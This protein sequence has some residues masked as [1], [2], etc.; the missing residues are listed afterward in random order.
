MENITRHGGRLVLLLIFLCMMAFGVNAQG[1]QAPVRWRTLVKMTSPTEGVIT[2]KCFLAEG[3]HVYGMKLPEG[4][5]KATTIDF[6]G[7]E[8]LKLTGALEAKPAAT[9]MED[10]M[11]GMKLEQW[12]GN[13]ELTQRFK[14]TGSAEK[15]KMSVKIHYMSCDN[16]NCRPPKAEVFTAKIPEFKK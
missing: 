10:P 3:T 16:K 15:A 11:F 14:L 2:I 13:F 6:A 7:C 12:T 1:Q 5:P 4:G 9:E 8:G